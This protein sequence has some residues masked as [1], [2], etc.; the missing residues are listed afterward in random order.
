MKLPLNTMRN[1][2]I[3]L[4]I[5]VSLA[6][7]GQ[8]A[9]RLILK[10][11]QIAA[12]SKSGNLVLNQERLQQFNYQNKQ[13]N[14]FRLQKSARSDDYLLYHSKSQ[15]P[16]Y[17]GKSQDELLDVID[18]TTRSEQVDLAYIDLN[19]PEAK[20]EAFASSAKIKF[21]GRTDGS[22]IMQ[23]LFFGRGNRVELASISDFATVTTQKGTTWHRKVLEFRVNS[24]WSMNLDIFS[25]TRE[26][27]S[28][29]VAKLKERLPGRNGEKS[30]GESVNEAKR[31]LKKSLGETDPD[32][33]IR[34][35]NELLGTQVVRH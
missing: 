1:F 6:V 9:C 24:D 14:V 18:K 16:I 11:D 17:R 34:L 20:A 4:L 27:V 28:R 23:K 10:K 12:K 29:Y 3:S 19:I 2:I 30:L 33:R 25:K 21:F 35:Q 32:I 26:N 5:L 13:Y 8:D 7:Q 31:A 15:N 22:A